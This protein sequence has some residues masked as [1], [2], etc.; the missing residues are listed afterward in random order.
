[1]FK[2]KL[3]LNWV[4]KLKYIMAARRI[5]WKWHCCKQIGFFPYTP[6]ICYWSLD[7][8]FKAKLKVESRYLKIQY[9]HQAAIL[10]L[11]LLKINRLLS[12]YTSNLLLKFRFDIQSQ[13]KIR[14]CKL[15]INQYGRKEAIVKVIYLKIYRIWPVA[16]SNIHLKFEIEIPKQTRDTL[17]K[18]CQYRVQIL[19]NPI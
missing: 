10:K 12:I 2:A 8:T 13:T 4:R 6:L 9:G 18:P 14:I 3:K 16:M 11:T 1:M 19:K 17:R 15:Q 7:K 5:F